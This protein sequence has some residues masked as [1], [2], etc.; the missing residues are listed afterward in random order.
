MSKGRFWTEEEIR[1]LKDEFRTKP[2]HELATDMGRSEDSI[3]MKA[4]TLGL[5]A[6][7]TWLPEEET[8]LKENY[9]NNSV[10]ELKKLLPTHSEKAITLRAFELGVGK[11]KRPSYKINERFFEEIND[12]SAYVLGVIA[13]DGNIIIRDEGSW[14]FKITSKD[15]EWLIAIRD[16]MGS[17]M[18]LKPVTGQWGHLAW[19]LI[20]T[21]RKMVLDLV[22]LGITPKKSLTIEFPDIPKE[23][24]PDFM[25]G[26]HDGNGCFSFHKN[27]DRI[28][29]RSSLASSLEFLQAWV[30]WLHEF[31]IDTE[32]IPHK[33]KTKIH[34]FHLSEKYAV[35][36]GDLIYSK[37]GI[38]LERKYLKYIEGKKL[39]ETR[40]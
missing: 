36:F 32:A 15:K 33:M 30:K 34:A 16:L 9:L 23:Y 10:K 3:R 12:A 40:N 39:L 6:P 28:V 25:R 19:D 14:N 27:H 31:G 18:K 17:D 37:P 29:L 24:I 26:Y 7:R 8:I 5:I 2:A 38:R 22:G 21:R 13:A 35:Q 4:F 1:I 20:I 11:Y